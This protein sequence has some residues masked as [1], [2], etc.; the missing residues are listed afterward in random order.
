MRVA[1]VCPYGLDHP[2]GV[3]GQVLGLARALERQDV[4]T[5]VVAPGRSVPGAPVPGAVPHDAT[6]PGGIVLVG[7][8]ISVP[9]NGSVAP[10]A[11]GPGALRRTVAVLRRWGADIVHLHEPLAPGPTWAVLAASLPGAHRV[12]TMH[13]AGGAGLYRALGPFARAALGRVEAVFAV[14]DEA[15]A[16]AAAALRGRSCPV[17]GNGVELDRFLAA[18]PV[19]TDGPTVLF[20]GRHEPRK[21]LSVLLQA[22]ER[23]GPG[24]PGH[25]WVVGD[26]PQTAE[27]RRRYPPGPRRRW[28]GRVGDAELAGLFAGSHV[29]CAPSLGGESFGVVLLEAMAARAAVVCSDIPGYAAAAG[30]HATLVPPGDVTALAG[31]LERVVAAVGTATGPA[32]ASALDAAVAHAGRHSMA[33][34]ASGY[35]RSYEELLGAP[36]S[37]GT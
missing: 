26:G 29:L 20:V 25:L 6:D 1:L 32:A 17:V 10:L 8:S 2:G 31:A 14:S 16:T 21:G 15:R 13:R 5:L 3:Q 9:A 30:G 33:A 12:A 19:R 24:W 35:L 27:L 28:L 23:L 18:A 11:L 7:R 37:A 36:R 34:L 22:T 4:T